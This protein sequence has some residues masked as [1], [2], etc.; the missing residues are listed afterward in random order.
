MKFID[1]SFLFIGL[2]LFDVFYS[3]V[4]FDILK[5]IGI[6]V[7]S[8]SLMNKCIAFI[9]IDAIFMFILYLIFRKELNREFSKFVRNFKKYFSF[10]FKWWIIGLVIM[11]GSNFVIQSVFGLSTARNENYVQD[12]LSK[13]PVYIVFSSCI[14]APFSE[15]LIFRKALRKMF[16][17]DFLFIVMSGVIFGL[18]HNLSS[19]GSLQM[20]Y[21]IPY[22]AFGAVFGYIYVKTNTIFT[23]MTF[24]FIHNS[25]LVG[26]SL[27]SL[28]V[29]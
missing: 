1:R 23:S 27:L 5:S 11:M 2:I 22:G 15:E 20:L 8:F 17:N 6:D 10:G 24:H 13:M 12:A 16:S 25:I 4:A 26:F 19:I 18:I 29:F 7:N 28:G 21:V 9:I 3:Y 14:M